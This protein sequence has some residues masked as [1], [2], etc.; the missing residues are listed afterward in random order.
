M[1]RGSRNSTF[2]TFEDKGEV[3]RYWAWV[4]A[5]E[6]PERRLDMDVDVERGE[7]KRGVDDEGCA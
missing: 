2:G 7:A 3:G 1:G 6:E 4:T 5:L